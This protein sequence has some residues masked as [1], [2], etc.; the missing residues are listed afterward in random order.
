MPMSI[1]T[2]LSS[3]ERIA[4]AATFALLVLFPVL[5]LLS[6]KN[7]NDAQKTANSKNITYIHKICSQ[8]KQAAKYYYA[9][10][11]M[12]RDSNPKDLLAAT[13]AT[14]YC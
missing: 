2:T 14:R 9:M 7:H 6:M 4:M 12:S 1:S 8:P 3:R 5:V 10:E 11:H 13:L